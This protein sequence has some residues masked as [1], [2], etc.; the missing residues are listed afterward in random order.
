M[1]FT[2]TM[3]LSARNIPNIY[4]G[5]GDIKSNE[6]Y[7]DSVSLCWNFS[8]IIFLGFEKDSDE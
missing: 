5:F 3:C 4:L 8:C 1:N 7:K 6:L 2:Q